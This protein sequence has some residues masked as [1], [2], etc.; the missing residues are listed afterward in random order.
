MHCINNKCFFKDLYKE[1]LHAEHTAEVVF[2]FVSLTKG[3]TNEVNLHIS[4]TLVMTGSSDSHSENR[5]TGP[6]HTHF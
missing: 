3:R 6:L 2:H 4:L 1:V 5:Q